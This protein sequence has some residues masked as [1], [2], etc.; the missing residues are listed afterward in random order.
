[1]PRAPRTFCDSK[2]YHIIIKGIDNQ[3]IFYDNQDRCVFLENIRKSQKQ[4]TY[5]VFAYCLMN[6]HVHMVIRV[7]DNLLSKSI[8][9]LTVRYVY[10][11]NKKYNREG[12]FVRNRFKSKKVQTKDYFLEVC[13]YVHRNPEKANVEKTE[14]YRWS[15]Y[16]DYVT[17]NKKGITSTDVL[18]YYFNNNRYEFE[19]YTLGIEKSYEINNFADF[20]LLQ[21]LTDEQLIDIIIKKFNIKS[22]ESIPKYLKN[23]SNEEEIEIVKEIGNIGGTNPRQIS[24]VLGI[25]RNKIYKILS[26]KKNRHRCHRSHERRKRCHFQNKLKKNLVK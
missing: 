5:T 7:D 9:S 24:R 22:T 20:E 23:H 18:M 16:K 10:Y 12:P 21:K 6:N 14:N 19:K 13:R 8:Q 25:N 2:I 3:D 17:L 26:D 15:S 4:Y 1:M 11:F